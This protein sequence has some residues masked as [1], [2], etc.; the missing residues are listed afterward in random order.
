M[1]FFD[2][3]TAGFAPGFI[4]LKDLANELKNVLFFP[5]HAKSFFAGTFEDH[6]IMYRGMIEAFN[7]AISRLGKDPQVE[8]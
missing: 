6:N 3:I 4:K 7:K 1:V 8:T 2:D 5:I